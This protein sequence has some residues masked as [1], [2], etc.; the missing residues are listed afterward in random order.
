M[1]LRHRCLQETFLR[2]RLSYA[3]PWELNGALKPLPSLQMAAHLGQRGVE[4]LNSFPQVDGS[5]IVRISTEES[6]GYREVLAVIYSKTLDGAKESLDGA[7][8]SVKLL[9]GYS[10]VDPKTERVL[11][12]G[13]GY[14]RREYTKPIDSLDHLD[15]LW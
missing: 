9:E 8:E 15:H 2:K 12:E 10:V 5:Q 6:D 4:F 1:I 3:V 13:L 7:K 14:Q 11:L